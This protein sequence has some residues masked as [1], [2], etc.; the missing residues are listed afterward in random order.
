MKLPDVNIWLALSLSG[1][2]HHLVARE[3]LDGESMPGGIRFCRATQQGLLRLLTTRA[4]LAPFGIEPL[5]NREAWHIEARLLADDR[6]AFAEEPAGVEEQWKSWAD[7]TVASP[8]LW[9][10]AWLAAFAHQSGFQLVTI[11]KAFAQFAG[12]NARILTT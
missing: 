8:K 3:W 7:R 5:T 2:S 9:M 6:I 10:D 12:L 4:V 11:D 1:H